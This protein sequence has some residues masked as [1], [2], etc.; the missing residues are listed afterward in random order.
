MGKISYDDK[1]RKGRMSTKLTR[2]H[3][4]LSTTMCGVWCFKHFTNLVKAK[5]TTELK[6]ALQQICDDL[7]QTTSNKAINDF[8]K[9]LNTWGLADGRHW[10]WCELGGRA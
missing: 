7:P 3:S 10:A 1:L 2:P 6:S 9:H 4:T 5:T 8:R